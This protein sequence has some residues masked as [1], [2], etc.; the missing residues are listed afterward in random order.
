MTKSH[1]ISAHRAKAGF[2]LAELLITVGIIGVVSTLGLR[3][4]TTAIAYYGQARSEGESDKAVQA[5]FQT[6]H[7]DVSSVLPTALTGVSVSGTVQNRAPDKIDSILILPVSV[8][9]F[10]DGRST[11]AWVKYSVQRIQGTAR[12]VRTAVPLHQNIP[13]NAGTDVVAG[14]IAFRVEHLDSEGRWL[15][16]WSGDASPIAVR[17]SLTVRDPDSLLAPAITRSLVFRVPAQ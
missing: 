1:R 12:L 7:E 9:T 8:P 17:V 10:A 3:A 15:P 4:Y 13:D 14:V 5:A 2:T 16:E 11:A 6:L